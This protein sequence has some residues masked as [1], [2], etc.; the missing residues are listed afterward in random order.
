[1]DLDTQR[2]SRAIQ[3]R[4]NQKQ[5][6][7]KEQGILRGLWGKFLKS[8]SWE[9]VAEKAEKADLG[10]TIDHLGSKLK[11]YDFIPWAKRDIRDF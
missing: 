2:E 5:R 7:R 3:Y 9:S 11:K 6:Y 10:Q 1:M 8:S 4:C